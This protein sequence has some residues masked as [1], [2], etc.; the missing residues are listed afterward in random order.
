MS[1]KAVSEYQ[2][3]ASDQMDDA[4]QPQL[5]FRNDELNTHLML[6]PSKCD[7]TSNGECMFPVSKQYIHNSN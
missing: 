1:F 3:V 4:M 5:L 2:T 6:S 7:A